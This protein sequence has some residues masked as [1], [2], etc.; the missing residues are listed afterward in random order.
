MHIRLTRT[1]QR[2]LLL[3]EQANAEVNLKTLETFFSNQHKLICHP[4]VSFKNGAEI[5]SK[6]HLQDLTRLYEIILQN[7]QEMQTLPGLEDDAAYQKE[8]E[9]KMT[10]YKAFR[11]VF[12]VSFHLDSFG[13]DYLHIFCDI[14]TFQVL[15]HSSDFGR[16]EEVE[17][18]N[19]SLP[20]IWAICARGL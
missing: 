6:N 9:A 7:L 18:G 3:V 15:L 14:I 4:T 16:T 19:G 12:A 17:R 20:A 13:N 1:V 10:T 2:N 5:K 11:L 8:V